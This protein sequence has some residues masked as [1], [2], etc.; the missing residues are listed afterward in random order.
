MRNRLLACLSLLAA[1]TLR[2]A[3]SVE[4]APA[5]TASAQS[6]V[7]ALLADKASDPLSG[8]LDSGLRLALQRQH[9]RGAA[10]ELGH[11]RVLQADADGRYHVDVLL[12]DATGTPA[13]AAEIAALPGAWLQS[14]VNGELR[15]WLPWQQIAALA[16][17]PE[18]RWLRR[19]MPAARGRS[20]PRQPEAIN[21]TQGLRAHAVDSARS[22]YGLTGLGQKICVL[23]DSID[24]L[25]TVQSSGDLPATI[26]ILPG[27]SGLGLGFSGEG[28]AMLEIVHDLAPDAELGFAAALT[29][30]ASFAQNIRDLRYN[31]ACDVLVD[32]LIYFNESPFQDGPIA[33]AVAEVSADGALYFAAATNFGNTRY[34]T[35][36]VYEGDFVDAGTLPALPGGR[37]NQFSTSLGSSNQIRVL[38]AGGA[39]SLFWTDPLGGSG[40]DYDVFVM[41]PDLLHVVDAGIDLQDGD[42][43]P[44]EMTGS[45]QPNDRIVIWKSDAAAPRFL[46]LSGLGSRFNLSTQGQTRGHSAAVAAYS[47]AAVDVNV[48]NGGRFMAGP[49]TPV[50][51]FSAE[52]PRR[53]Y[54]DAAGGLLNPGQPSLLAD[55]GVVRAKP[56][57]AAADGVATATPGFSQFYG[58][59]AA[60]PHL[61]A[62]A[63]LLRQ[64][65]P[66]ADSAAIRA[67]LTSSA[68]DIEDP[69]PDTLSGAGIAMA[70]SALAALG[71]IP[72]ARLRR[73]A[74]SLIEIDGDLDGI[75]EPGETLD[76]NLLL[77]NDGPASAT[78]VLATLSSATPGI[79]LLRA[80]ASYPDIGSGAAVSPTLPFRLALA[81]DFPC[82]KAIVLELEVHYAGGSPGISPQRFGGLAI[83]VGSA[84]ALSEFA[85]AGPAV[86]IP[87]ADPLG[88]AVGLTLASGGQRAAEIGLRFDGA[89]CSADLL[90]TG[91]GLQHTYVGDLEIRLRAPGGSAVRLLQRPRVGTGDNAGNHLC[92]T[93]FSDAAA[94]GFADQPAS[95]EPFSGSFRSLEPL[96]I[97]DGT[98]V[99]GSWTLEISDHASPD[100]GW[101]RAFSLLLRPAL[102]DLHQP[103]LLHADGFE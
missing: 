96:A 99:D 83:A 16:S 42:D 40:N 43:D 48:A 10:V 24:H 54:F 85:Y 32:D 80:S 81:P 29:G 3:W 76:L 101:L 79:N 9:G 18:V 90:A 77:H 84:G 64:S 37:V 34:G 70:D 100:A 45:L 31:A 65:A 33:Q 52:G 92:Q 68:L 74:P 28:T 82:G 61:A 59:S 21:I 46:H 62:I 49:A 63:T 60:A 88:V 53:M 26:D 50:E 58:T 103:L 91:V 12:K 6:E 22:Q 25:G 2:P 13:V 38:N 17:R 47:A 15:A 39:A 89:L 66:A 5:L 102:C 69:G 57:L 73:G 30:V 1:L 95:A 93:T 98:L 87:D 41:S 4:A 19:A 44:Y 8:K 71:A 14:A 67:A 56:D 78:A 51:P 55:G 75:P 97:F 20:A 7:R 11:L 36:S 27:Q 86:A 35:A 94:S 72:V 23:S